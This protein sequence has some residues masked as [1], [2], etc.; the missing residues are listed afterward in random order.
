MSRKQ[1]GNAF[2][3]FLIGLALGLLVWW[4]IPPPG[5]EL[6]SEGERAVAEEA[7]LV[8]EVDNITQLSDEQIKKFELILE[9]HCNWPDTCKPDSARDLLEEIRGWVEAAPITEGLKIELREQIDRCLDPGLLN[10]QDTHVCDCKNPAPCDELKNVIWTKA[11]AASK[12]KKPAEAEQAWLQVKS[13][14]EHFPTGRG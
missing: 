8:D 13:D 11:D 9:N 12:L 5:A 1:R 2:V 10:E 4:F 6:L 7:L 3:P 14:L